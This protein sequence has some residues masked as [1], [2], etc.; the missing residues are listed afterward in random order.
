MNVRFLALSRSIIAFEEEATLACAM[1]SKVEK[2][3]ITLCCR[4]NAPAQVRIR[5]LRVNCAVP[6]VRAG[7]Q[8]GA[9]D[10]LALSMHVDTRV[11]DCLGE[12]CVN[13]ILT[14]VA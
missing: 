11:V 6:A 9:V 1:P 4:L 8:E 2:F 14:P 7:I 13:T 10:E 12:K 5:R 3:D